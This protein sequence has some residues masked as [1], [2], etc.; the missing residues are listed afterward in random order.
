MDNGSSSESVSTETGYYT[1]PISVS[2]ATSILKRN[3]S[4]NDRPYIASS[5]RCNNHQVD[6]WSKKVLTPISDRRQSVPAGR[7]WGSW[8]L[9]DEGRQIKKYIELKEKNLFRQITPEVLEFWKDFFEN[10]SIEEMH[11]YGAGTVAS[12][13]AIIQDYIREWFSEKKW[14]MLFSQAPDDPLYWEKNYHKHNM[15]IEGKVLPFWDEETLKD[16]QQKV[17]A[18]LYNQPRP[19]DQTGIQ[20]R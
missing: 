17:G 12:G 13:W 3:I 6:L 1:N 11:N 19:Q 8:Q 10:L 9:Y 18:I 15:Y 5:T 14:E 7:V 20:M 2:D 4:K 16:I